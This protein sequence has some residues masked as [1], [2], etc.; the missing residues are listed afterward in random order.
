LCE[1]GLALQREIG[2]KEGIAESLNLLALV[3]VEQRA[4]PTAQQ[5]SKE[6]LEI[7]REIGAQ[8][9]VCHALIHLG[10]IALILKKYAQS[11]AYFIESL[12]VANAIG[13]KLFITYN[14]V[15]LAG[16]ALKMAVA[17]G[18]DQAAAALYATQL[19]GAATAL[20][21]AIN[22]VWV[23]T[24]QQLYER[25]A[26]TAQAILGETAWGAALASGAA[27][28]LEAAVTYALAADSG[29]TNHA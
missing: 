25:I 11:R 21:A 5:Y 18:T 14:W 27:M 3:A 7:A 22:G 16:V 9:L 2:I 8:R 17:Q 28:S 4:H 12:Q 19:L 20:C 29:R 26:A 23:P 10:H 1:E 6:S 15:G 13:E 24:E